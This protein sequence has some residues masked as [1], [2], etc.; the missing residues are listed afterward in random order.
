M[1]AYDLSGAC[2]TIEAF[3]DVLTNWYI[4]RS[5][6]RFWGTG[7]DRDSDAQDAFDTL[8]TVLDVLC[9]VAAPL[10]PLV[11][12]EIWQGLTRG[13]GGAGTGAAAGAA[14]PSSVHLADWPD[15]AGLAADPDL[16][17]GMDRVREVCSLA[18]SIRKA[19]GLRARLPLPALTV[20]AADAERLRPFVDL[21]ADEV[22]V[23][24]VVLSDEPDQ[25]A[26][27]TLTVVFKVA[28]PRL[29]PATQAAAAAAK[30]G[31]WE[32][33]DAGRARVGE[34]TLEPGEFDLRV[35]PVDEATTRTLPGTTGLVML[36]IVPTEDLVVEGR[37]RDLVRAVQ[38][39]RRELDLA[40]TDRIALAV[41]G[42]GAVLDAARAHRAWIQEQVLAVDIS[43]SADRD[44][45]G[46]WQEAELADGS[47]GAIRV[48]PTGAVTG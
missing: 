17:E 44:G 11:T 33:L 12:E 10:L 29:G 20:A 48:A 46:G 19:N 28:A 14:W 45:E 47:H 23:R 38:Q 15:P 9:R 35:K 34:S 7:A 13:G 43:V 39:R 27:R 26:S 32:L 6:D 21:I 24:S 1:D 5:R 16:V 37:A 40:V 3:L 4:R 31:D 36:D 30:R 8:A 25:F 41:S 42:D 18:H 2:E 22:N